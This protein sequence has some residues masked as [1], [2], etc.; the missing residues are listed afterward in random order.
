MQTTLEVLNQLKS[1]TRQN[2]PNDATHEVYGLSFEIH[3]FKDI[4]SLIIEGQTPE[5]KEAVLLM[6]DKFAFCLKEFNSIFINTP[7]FH[8]ST[9][10]NEAR[11][12]VILH[13]YLHLLYPTL[14]ENTIVEYT[15]RML[16][17]CGIRY[18]ID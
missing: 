4:N 3:K 5:Q 17:A 2:L 12:A 9:V 15:D 7:L 1:L 11:L 13:E 8:A 6:A 10:S 14:G 16:N 18:S